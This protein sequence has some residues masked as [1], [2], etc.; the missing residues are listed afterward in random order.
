MT[1]PLI[2][3]ALTVEV[4]AAFTARRLSADIVQVKERVE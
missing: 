4:M 3:I 1:E 2:Q